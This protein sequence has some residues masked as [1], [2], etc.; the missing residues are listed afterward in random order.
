MSSKCRSVTVMTRLSEPTFGDAFVRRYVRA[1]RSQYRSR[2]KPVCVKGRVSGALDGARGVGGL[3]VLTL[4]FGS[5]NGLSEVPVFRDLPAALDL[6][7]AP[8]CLPG[9]V[10]VLVVT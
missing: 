6:R 2:A 8:D 7:V 10:S 3:L 1:A 9:P 4:L 5:G